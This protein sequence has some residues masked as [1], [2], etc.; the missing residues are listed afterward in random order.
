MAAGPTDSL[1]DVPGLAVGQVELGVSDETPDGATGVTAV[2]ARHGALGAVDVRGAAPATRETDALSA[3]ASGERVH[4]VILSG[5]SV[6]GLAA[7][8]GATVELERRGIGLAITPA[9]ASS[10]GSGGSAPG[11]RAPLVIPIVAA[12]S[13]FDFAHGDGSVR[14]GAADG[15]AAVSAALDGPGDA[16]PRSGN[17][18]AGTGA[19]TGKIAPPTLKGGIGHASVVLPAAEGPSLVV[20][21]LAIVNAAGSLIDPSSRRPWAQWGG[22]HAEAPPPDFDDIAL[23]RMQTT[24]VVVGTNA[25]LHKAQLARVC[26]MAH[27]GLARAIRPAHTSVDGDVVFALAVPDAEEHPAVA[28]HQW[29]PAGVSVVGAL[30]ADVVTRAVL[31]ALLSAG[32]SGGFEAFRT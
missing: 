5:R 30:A 19:T 1:V 28:A 32:P 4:A 9:E 7:A 15:R 26:A 21:A 18:G 16:R 3:F 25:R 8:D 10:E 14:P 17:A 2:V 6:F 13:I 29:A 27:D 12:A 22:F 24:L 20:G 11:I 31:D 23:A